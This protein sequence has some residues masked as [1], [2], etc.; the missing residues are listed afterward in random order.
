MS[1]G[2]RRQGAGRPMGARDRV[3]RGRNGFDKLKT[4]VREAEDA[5]YLFSSD[6]KEFT[7]T[8]VQ[9]LQAIY[10]AESLPVKIRLYAASKAADYEPKLEMQYDDTGHAIL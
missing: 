8:A 2:G 1:K 7:G 3:P 9:L 10:K 4:M 6:D 5:E